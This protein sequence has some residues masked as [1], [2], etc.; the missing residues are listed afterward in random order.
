MILLSAVYVFVVHNVESHFI[1][2]YVSVVQDSFYSIAV[3]SLITLSTVVLLGL[4][5]AYHALEVQVINYCISDSFTRGAVCNIWDS[6][7]FNII[8]LRNVGSSKVW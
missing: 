8:F 6:K 2:V 5:V 3:R 7:L 1:T 4:I